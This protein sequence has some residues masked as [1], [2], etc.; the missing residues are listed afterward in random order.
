MTVVREL[1]NYAYYKSGIV[2]PD[3][4]TPD[5]RQMQDGLR[6]LN[7]LV[8]ELNITGEFIPYIKDDKFTTVP[9]QE[10]YSIQTLLNDMSS[11]REVS[12]TWNN[13]RYYLSQ[14]TEKE[15]KTSPR[16][17]N[18]SSLPYEYYIQ[19][20]SESGYNLSFYFIPD[21]EYTITI[22]YKISY[23]ELSIGQDLTQITD[24]FFISFLEAKLAERLCLYYNIDPPTNLD[25]LLFKLEKKIKNMTPPD[26]ISRRSGF[27]RNNNTIN[28]GDVN[29]GKSWR[30]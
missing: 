19:R 18:I 3:A 5:S 2:S 10:T 9:G 11:I 21:K 12:L 7:Q 28:Y 1:I 23:D 4:E 13:I 6:L 27:L 26:L 25:K 8:S 14:A 16:A 24:N 29:L 15:Y 22:T 30:P 17:D 20:I